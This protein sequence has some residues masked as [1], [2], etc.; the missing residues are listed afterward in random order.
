MHN[1]RMAAAVNVLISFIHLAVAD[2]SK[3]EER[4][5]LAVEDA[6]TLTY[7]DVLKLNYLEIEK[8]PAAQH[9]LF[10]G[11]RKWKEEMA[12]VGHQIMAEVF[13]ERGPAPIQPR[14]GEPV[15]AEMVAV[16]K[17]STEKEFI[18]Q[19]LAKNRRKD[20]L[21]VGQTSDL[22][23]GRFNL[24]SLKEAAGVVEKLKKIAEEN[25]LDIE[26]ITPR[27]H[28]YSRGARAKANYF[29]YP[30]YHV[31][32]KN[33]DGAQFEWQIG[34]RYLNDYFERRKIH[35]PKGIVLP[36]GI[37]NNLHDFAYEILQAVM[38]DATTNQEDQ[39]ILERY[40]I[41]ATVMEMNKLAAEAGLGAEFISHGFEKR[42]NRMFT[43][44]TF[45]LSEMVKHEG[46]E[47][48]NKHFHL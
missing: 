10:A 48:I 2:S 26:I 9:V 19:V 31:V 8:S 3:V 18:T 16:L 29:S 12:A 1:L 24:E 15:Q 41:T 46:A 6:K 30:R 5:H 11:T 33:P 42:A 7:A 23:R 44:V 36:P 32:L 27:R 13:A 38:N 28:L 45:I 34:T 35:V 14:F 37:Q 20:Y 25:Q 40:K 22:A 43:K 17:R 21:S 39:R 47:Y 4:N